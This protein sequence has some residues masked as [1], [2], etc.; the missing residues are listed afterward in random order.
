MQEAR[1]QFEVVSGRSH[2]DGEAALSQSN[3]QGLLDRQ[4]IVRMRCRATFQPAD[5]YWNH[6]DVHSAFPT[7]SSRSSVTAIAWRLSSLPAQRDS[8]PGSTAPSRT[9]A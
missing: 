4:Q 3:L 8:L 1:G 5:R 9:T 2:R 7:L 6:R